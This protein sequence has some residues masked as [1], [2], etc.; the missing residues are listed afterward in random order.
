[1]CEFS[2]CDKVVLMFNSDSNRYV[3]VYSENKGKVS[4]HYETKQYVNFF[5]SETKGYVMCFFTTNNSVD[6]TSDTKG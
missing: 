3:N 2:S 1:M 6:F 5:Y 4:F